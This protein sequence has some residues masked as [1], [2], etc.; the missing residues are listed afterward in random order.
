MGEALLHWEWPGQEDV[1]PE[2]AAVL[3][4]MQATPAGV[5]EARG[6][7]RETQRTLSDSNSVMQADFLLT[8]K[9]DFSVKL[10]SSGN[11]MIVYS[12]YYLLMAF[13]E[14]VTSKCALMF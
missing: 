5:R 14:A 3:A 6:K 8:R 1:H 9:V 12:C 13:T 11:M 4:R 7:G 10:R 2:R